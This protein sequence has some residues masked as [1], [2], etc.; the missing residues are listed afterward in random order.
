MSKP[1]TL[2]EK[3]YIKKHSEL[4]AKSTAIARHLGISVST[5]RK[6]RNRIKKGSHLSQN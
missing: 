2:L 6:W 4:G 1:I 5:V 3:N